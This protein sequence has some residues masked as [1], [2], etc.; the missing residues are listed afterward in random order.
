MLFHL[1]IFQAKKE[2]QLVELESPRGP[3]GILIRMDHMGET[4]R[5]HK[6]GPEADLLV[7]NRGLKP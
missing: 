4:P 6:R 1:G 2:F 7:I 5:E 3:T